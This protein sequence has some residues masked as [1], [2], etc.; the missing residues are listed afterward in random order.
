MSY[1]HFHIVVTMLGQKEA[2]PDMQCKDMLR[3]QSIVARPGVSSSNTLDI[4]ARV[5]VSHVD[6]LFRE[7]ILFNSHLLRWSSMVLGIFTIYLQFVEQKLYLR[8]S[9]K[10]RCDFVA[11]P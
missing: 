1:L 10:S 6:P 4:L 7:N 8:G 3:I 5:V 9:I 2:P 11:N